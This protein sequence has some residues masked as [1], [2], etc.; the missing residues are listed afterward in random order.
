[1]LALGLTHHLR[2]A[3]QVPFNKQAEFLKQLAP[4]AL[5]EFPSPEDSQVRAMLSRTPVFRD[6]YSAESFE[7]A[8]SESFT[9]EEVHG[10]PDSA[11]RLYLMRRRGAGA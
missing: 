4:V 11:R 5:V 6:D 2:L 10:I 7:R 8:F 9:L 1:M 3:N